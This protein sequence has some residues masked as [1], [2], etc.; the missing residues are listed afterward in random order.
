MNNKPVKIC[1]GHWRY[2][3]FSTS[4]NRVFDIRDSS[5]PL[6]SIVQVKHDTQIAP[7]DPS[8]LSFVFP[9]A[10]VVSGLGKRRDCQ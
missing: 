10:G 9:G 7:S 4:K 1:C 5:E 6:L 2:V 3:I 8:N